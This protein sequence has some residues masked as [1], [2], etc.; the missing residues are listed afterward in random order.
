MDRRRETFLHLDGVLYSSEDPRLSP[1]L[2]ALLERVRDQGM[3]PE[4]A[5][6]WRE[7]RRAAPRPPVQAERAEGAAFARGVRTGL[8][9][10]AASGVLLWAAQGDSVSGLAA[11]GGGTAVLGVFKLLSRL[12]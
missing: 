3:S 9:L 5:A 7:G 11:V 1:E 12:A 2:R 4:L 10:A 8:C 6:D